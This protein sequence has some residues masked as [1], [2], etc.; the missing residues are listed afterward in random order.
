MALGYEGYV[1]IG[2]KYALGTGTAVPR[3]LSRIDSQG[4]Y[5]GKV[6]TPVDEI[7]IGAP[8][9]YG[10]EVFDGSVS[11][12]MTKDIFQLL[13]DWIYDRESQKDI[14]FSPRKGGKTKFTDTFWNSISISANAGSVMEGSL[15]FVA[16]ERA[17]Y[18]YGDAGI[19]GYYENT[20]GAGL[21]CP[22]ATGMPQP[23]NPSTK[24]NQNPVPYWNS[25]V[26]L[27]SDIFDFESW[28]LDFSQD[29]VK[30][31]A[32]MATTGP[33]APAFVGVG[34]MVITLN[35]TWMWIDETSRPSAFPTDTYS[36]AI[37]TVAGTTIKFKTLEKQTIS[38][39]VQSPDSTTP[40][41]MEY[42]VYELD[43]P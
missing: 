2:D 21:L 18:D 27:G 5:G 30:F 33:Q 34:P 37:V 3:A 12:E 19:Q 41:S 38:D 40:V 8:R 9:I 10:W 20:N 7:G 11:F 26:Q 16:I 42:A 25:S 22:L 15:G 35:G 36:T 29:V 13:K 24:L 43:S 14:F 4:A 39:D 17:E 1:K 31:P 28:S 6:K 32:C 23:L